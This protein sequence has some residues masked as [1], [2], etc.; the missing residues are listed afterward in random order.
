[1]EIMPPPAV[2]FHT[3][4]RTAMRNGSS[5][6][7]AGALALADV[8]CVQKEEPG[9]ADGTAPGG[10]AAPLV[11]AGCPEF[12]VELAISHVF[13]EKFFSLAADE[14]AMPF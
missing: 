2:C 7:P 6:E 11:P 5:P 10:S 12:W 8:A 1:M 13:P 3:A 9:A 14:A 4:A